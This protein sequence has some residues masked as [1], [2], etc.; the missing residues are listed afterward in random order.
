MK[1][2]YKYPITKDEETG[3]FFI[4]VPEGAEVISAVINEK[5][6]P[7]YIYAIVDPGLIPSVKR[8]VLWLGTGWPLGKEDQERMN[9]YQFLGTFQDGWYIWHIWVEPEDIDLGE[10]FGKFFDLDADDFI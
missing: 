10:V 8:E 3:E 9:R 6:S 5:D 2:I 4:E 1:T 7:G